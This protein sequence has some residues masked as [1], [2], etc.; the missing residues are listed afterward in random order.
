[1]RLQRSGGKAR[2]WQDCNIRFGTAGFMY[3]DWEGIVYPQP[4]PAHF[5]QLRY[6]SELFDTVEINSSY[7]GPP[8]AKTSASWVR[9]VNDNPNFRFTAKLWKRFT[10]ERGSAW[11]TT[12][13]DRVRE[14]F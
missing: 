9:R 7:Y 5:D 3:K 6:M 14:G 8:L 4:R 1:M 12:D 2:E 10:H 13:V 11:T